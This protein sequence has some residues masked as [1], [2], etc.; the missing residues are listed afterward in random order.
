MKKGINNNNSVSGFIFDIFNYIFL[1]L[2]G[3]AALVPFLYIL[4][5]SFA[6][7]GE[8]SARAFFIIPHTFTTEAY[9]L[10]LKSSTLYR[11]LGVSVFITLTGTLINLFCTFTFAYPLSKRGLIGRSFLL[12]CVV[13][14]MVFGGGMI[15]TYLVVKNLHLINTYWSL[16]LPGAIN[17]GNFIIIKNFFQGLPAELME[18]AEIDGCSEIGILG[19]I[20][21]P[22]SMPIVATFG[23]FYAVGHW[24]DYFSSLLY[25]SNPKMWPLQ[26][27][28]RQIVM[29]S[30]GALTENL[31]AD[32]VA[33]AQ[34]IK[35][36]TIVVGVVPIMCVYPF[37]QKHFAK[38][39]L[40]GAVKG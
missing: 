2:Y 21:L 1:G 32:Y 31:P 40:V 37:L 4:A 36:A 8:I 7:E 29:L 6:T 16:L 25:I 30:Q 38:G 22:L 39:A 17:T 18:A 10:I 20:V 11:A 13:F 14:T 12:N 28:L 23:L 26:V 34:A 24:N 27:L 35:M 19:R 9:H 33:P 15:P 3:L 5:A